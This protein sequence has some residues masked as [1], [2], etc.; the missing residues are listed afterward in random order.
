[1]LHGDMHLKVQMVSSKCCFCV[2]SKLKIFFCRHRRQ[3][4]GAVFRALSRFTTLHI[5]EYLRLLSFRSQTYLDSSVSYIGIF[6]VCHGFTVVTVSGLETVSGGAYVGLCH[7][8]VGCCNLGFVNNI[9][10]QAVSVN[11]ALVWLSTVA[12]AVVLDVGRVF[13]FGVLV[14][15][16]QYSFI[17]C[18]G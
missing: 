14:M 5:V 9:R 17:C 13:R 7:D 1:M 2:L 11:W 10:T 8:V 4:L 16:V 15:S 3:F 12:V 6:S 18:V